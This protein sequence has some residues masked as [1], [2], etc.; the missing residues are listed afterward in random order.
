MVVDEGVR[1]LHALNAFP[2]DTEGYV[3][4]YPEEVRADPWLST[5]AGCR[6]TKGNPWILLVFDYF[7]V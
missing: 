5:P 4:W 6:E 2:N 1:Y 7:E 3:V